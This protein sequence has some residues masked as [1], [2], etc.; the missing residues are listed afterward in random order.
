MTPLYML[1]YDYV[2]DY[3][4]RREPV[5]PEHI[6]LIREQYA[7]GLLTQAGAFGDGA[8]G[9]VIVF[10]TEAAAIAFPGRDP[11]VSSGVVSDWRVRQWNTVPLG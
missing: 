4:E 7:A 2:D 9:A 5:R 8:P 3:L 11:Y 1:I 10:T 6:A